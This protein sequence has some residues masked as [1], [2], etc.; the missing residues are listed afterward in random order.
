MPRIQFS[1]TMILQQPQN[2]KSDVRRILLLCLCP[3]HRAQ[4][5]SHVLALPSGYSTI[6][7]SAGNAFAIRRFALPRYVATLRSGLP[8][9]AQEA[10]HWM[11]AKL[12]R[13]WPVANISLVS[14]R[15]NSTSWRSELEQMREPCAPERSG[16]TSPL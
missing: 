6:R 7:R 14:N 9:V 3:S 4:C 15:A 13:V 10:A 16:G 11:H 12:V 8:A 5:T 1:A 2:I